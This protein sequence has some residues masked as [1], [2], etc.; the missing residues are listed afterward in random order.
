VQAKPK[1]TMAS[2]GTRKT[3]SM[4]KEKMVLIFPRL[5]NIKLHKKY[6][7]ISPLTGQ[8]HKYMPGSAWQHFVNT[9]FI[10]LTSYQESM[11]RMGKHYL[12]HFI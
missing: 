8:C 6:F 12:L 3:H 5:W 2:T 7:S 11:F 9:L 10:N 4:C 1:S